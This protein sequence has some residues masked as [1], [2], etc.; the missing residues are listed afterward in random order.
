[1]EDETSTSRR[2][3]LTATGAGLCSAIALAGCGSPGGENETDGESPAGVDGEEETPMGGDEESP[4][5]EDDGLDE[6]GGNETD[7]NMTDD[8]ETG[9]GMGDNATEEN[10]TGGGSEAGDTSP[11]PGESE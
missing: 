9:G 10:A 5:E 11:E 8:N 1:M 7:D 4:L 2:K 3:V 6:T